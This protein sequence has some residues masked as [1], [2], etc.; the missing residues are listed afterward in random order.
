MSDLEVFLQQI[1]NGL[2][3]GMIIA[4]IALGYTLVYG[5]VE[6]IN[7]A[8]GDLVMLGSFFALSLVGILGLTNPELSGFGFYSYLTFIFFAVAIFSAFFNWLTDKI[9]YLP[10][11][12]SSRL[13]QLVTAIG[14]SFIFM[15]IGLFWGGLPLEVFNQGASPAAPKNFPVIISNANFF[16]DSFIQFG[17]KDL[18]VVVVTLPIMGLLTY[19]VK[20]SKLGTAMRAVAQNPVAAKLMGI[21]VDQVIGAAFIIGGALAGVAGLIYAIYNNTI[22]FQMGYRIGIDGFTAA[23]LGGIGNLPGAVLGGLLIGLIRSLSDQYIET[24]WTG[25]IVFLVLILVLVFRPS[26]LLGSKVKE[27]V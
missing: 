21:N 6:L 26:G 10:L 25:T 13:S 18:L 24:R 2:S 9:F 23:V 11:R 17:P 16:G 20:F 8:H 12:N 22:S 4:L 27:K 1:I 19:F 15:N 5:I 3:N 7:F 14:V